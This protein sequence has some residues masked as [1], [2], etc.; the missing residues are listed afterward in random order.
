MR[1]EKSYDAVKQVVENPNSTRCPNC[2]TSL[3]HARCIMA[4][5][6]WKEARD[7]FRSRFDS[8][9]A[10]Q[11][12]RYNLIQEAQGPDEETMDIVAHVF[13]KYC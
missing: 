8:Q 6:K 5:R 10:M 9:S 12:A 11:R 13:C 3:T 1:N 4:G 2:F 7:W